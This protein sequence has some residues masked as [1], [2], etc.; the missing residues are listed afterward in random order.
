MRSHLTKHSD[1]AQ[2]CPEP[3]QDRL[4]PCSPRLEPVGFLA[5]LF[6]GVPLAHL[7]RVLVGKGDCKGCAM[8]KLALDC[9]R[10]LV[11]VDNFLGDRQS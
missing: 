1:S 3:A 9:D 10:P 5:V 6:V 2:A 7:T 4:C 11:A 8:T